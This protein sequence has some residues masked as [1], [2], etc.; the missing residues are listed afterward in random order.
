MFITEAKAAETFHRGHSQIWWGWRNDNQ[1]WQFQSNRWP[2]GEYFK[3]LCGRGHHT[4]DQEQWEVSGDNKLKP[5]WW[6]SSLERTAIS[7]KTDNTHWKQ[8][9]GR[10]IV[11]NKVTKKQLEFWARMGFHW[12]GK[13]DFHLRR[14]GDRRR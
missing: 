8:E 2:V 1:M 9:K 7:G 13:Q 11:K 6:K 4:V 5:L 10:L 14:L 12:K 3:M